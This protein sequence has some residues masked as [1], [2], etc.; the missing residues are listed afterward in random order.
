FFSIFFHAF[1]SLLPSLQ[2]TGSFSKSLATVRVN[3]EMAVATLALP[4]A[5]YSQGLV[6]LPPKQRY[7]R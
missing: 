7:N 2:D 4:R 5:L 1:C 3:S 6:G